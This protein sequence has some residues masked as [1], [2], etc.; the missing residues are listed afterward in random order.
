[1]KTS[2]REDKRIRNE[3]IYFE[4]ETHM[5]FK[6]LL[7]EQVVTILSKKYNVGRAQIYNIIKSMK[8]LNTQDK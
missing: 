6:T 5:S 1:M 2:K 8:A 7:S 3:Q 4:Y